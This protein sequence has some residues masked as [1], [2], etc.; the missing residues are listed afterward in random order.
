MTPEKKP[1]I[2]RYQEKALLK[3]LYAN[4]SADLVSIT[5]GGG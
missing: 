5:G 3:E 4:S 1:F 2:G